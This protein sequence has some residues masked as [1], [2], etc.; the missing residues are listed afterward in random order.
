MRTGDGLFVNEK[1]GHLFTHCDNVAQAYLVCADD[2]NKTRAWLMLI[3][4]L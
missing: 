4:H 2:E 3:C 1:G